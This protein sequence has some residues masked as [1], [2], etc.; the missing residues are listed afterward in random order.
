MPEHDQGIGCLEKTTH[1][2][3]HEACSLF[4]QPVV[5]FRT[6]ARPNLQHNF[7][8][9]SQAVNRRCANSMATVVAIRE[10]VSTITEQ[11]SC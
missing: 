2:G 3:K 10:L 6:S 1:L 9:I 4:S 5:S 11:I 8:V 7:C